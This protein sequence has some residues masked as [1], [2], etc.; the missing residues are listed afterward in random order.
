MNI[1]KLIVTV[2]TL[3]SIL[4]SILF[5]VSSVVA[6]ELNTPRDFHFTNYNSYLSFIKAGNPHKYKSIFHPFDEFSVLGQFRSATFDNGLYNYCY[7]YEITDQNGYNLQLLA[8]PKGNIYIAAQK[9]IFFPG[10]MQDMTKLGVNKSGSLVRGP[11]EYVYE[12]GLLTCIVWKSGETEFAISNGSVLHDYPLTGE[13]TIA[14]RLL[15]K[16]RKTALLN[17][18]KIENSFIGLD[19]FSNT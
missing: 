6:T 2:I 15:S 13:T 17:L 4:S 16:D 14:S 9:Y 7:D 11:L 12:D 10:E 8:Q 1:R 19:Q 3:I 5:S 18:G